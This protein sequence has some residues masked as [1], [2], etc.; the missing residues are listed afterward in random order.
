MKTTLARKKFTI[1][2]YQLLGDTGVIK[3]GERVE[4]ING[5]IIEMSPVN[6][7]HIACVNRLTMLFA[8]QLAGKAIV[9]VQNP[10]VLD[11]YNEPQLDLVLFKH[12]DDFYA[13]EKATPA[14]VILAVEVADTTLGY[15]R[16]IKSDLYATAGILE[17]WIVNVQKKEI[18][19]YT[20]PGEGRYR[21]FKTFKTGD[22]LDLDGID[23]SILV[24][25]VI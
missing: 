15:D 21:Q 13:K 10:V 11:Q 1:E 14:D 16:N 9:S 8:S 24:E 19:K 25:D 6:A 12:R 3:P 23:L 20:H 22:K 7:P 2:D 18:E 4:L 5:E 17:F